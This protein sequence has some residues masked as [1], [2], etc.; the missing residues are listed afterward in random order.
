MEAAQVYRSKG[1]SYAE[2]GRILRVSPT[3][4]YYALKPRVRKVREDGSPRSVWVSDDH[5]RLVRVWAEE[6]QV[7]LGE[8]VRRLIGAEAELREHLKNPAGSEVF[9]GEPTL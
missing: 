4:V 7:S 5:W 1:M 2:I 3:G 8:V 6:H 9:E